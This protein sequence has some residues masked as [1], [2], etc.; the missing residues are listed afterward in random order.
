MISHIGQKKKFQ[1]LYIYMCRLVF[2]SHEELLSL[3]RI[4]YIGRS[5]SLQLPLEFILGP[6]VDFSPLRGIYLSE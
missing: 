4:I 3:Q 5:E 6:S 1:M 2:L